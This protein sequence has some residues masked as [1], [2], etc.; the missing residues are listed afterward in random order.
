MEGRG[1]EAVDDGGVIDGE[2]A[3][4]GVGGDEECGETAARLGDS[5]H[6]EDAGVVAELAVVFDLLLVAG[7]DDGGGAQ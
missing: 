4:A 1:G 7:D 2:D 6:E 3:A 5:V